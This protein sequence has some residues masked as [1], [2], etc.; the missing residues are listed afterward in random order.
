MKIHFTLVCLFLQIIAFAQFEENVTEMGNWQDPDA[1]IIA[2]NW[3]ASK[4]HD[5]WGVE[6][7]GKE[8]AIMSTRIGTHIIDVEDAADLKVLH[9]IPAAYQGDFAVHRDFH[10]YN[11]YLYVVCDEG[12]STLQ[13]IDIRNLPDTISVVYD[14]N[15]LFK[16]SHNIFIDTANAK[17]YA[18]GASSANVL[19]ATLV[20]PA[21]P[22]LMYKYNDGYIHDL[23][24]RDNIGYLNK[25]DDGLFVVE[26]GNSDF[27]V[28]GSLTNYPDQGYNHSGWLS[29]DGNYYALCDE[30]HG[31]K[32]KLLDVSDPADI[33]FV[34]LFGADVTNNS[35]AHN[36]IIKDNYAFVSYYYDGLQVFDIS[37]PEEV[38]KVG[39][40]DTYLDNNEAS[41]KGAWGVYPNLKSE[42]IL[43][44]DMQTGLYVFEMEL[45]PVAD[46]EIDFDG[47][48]TA[49]FV[50]KSRWKPTAY[51]WTING[52][53][54]VVSIEANPVYD[55]VANDITEVCLTV[56]NAKGEST[57]CKEFNLVSTPNYFVNS[58]INYNING[59]NIEINYVLNNNK[60]ISYSLIDVN[61]KVIYTN[62]II[63]NA[64][65]V[66]HKISL[67]TTNKLLILS[68]QSGNAVW[69][70]KLVNLP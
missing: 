43:V 60:Q 51:E 9:T 59:D 36:V 31:L 70:E 52:E 45:A 67:P 50:N 37:N 64:G 55:L 10:D 27:T 66:N 19:V 21:K 16:T 22:K 5:I 48:T 32:V 28:L 53:T 6:V 3:I 39:Q 47:G 56:S 49:S 58:N 68:L 33:K 46:F 30:T 44:S 62:T 57:R 54:E 26:F 24:V 12:P 63:E 18:A 1:P 40:Y 4:Y 8:Y 41:Y 23:Y 20:N 34:S 29:E 7:N 61:G 65:S 13:I 35:I 14:S 25:A 2:P 69:S 15:E 42:K 38:N 17:L 11:G